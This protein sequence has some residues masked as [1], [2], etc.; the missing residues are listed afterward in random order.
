MTLT[1]LH[2]I[3]A[4]LTL[5]IV[6]LLVL[7]LYPT[8]TVAAARFALKTEFESGATLAER[9]LNLGDWPSGNDNTLLSHFDEYPIKTESPIDH[10]HLGS[11]ALR[12][13]ATVE[14]KK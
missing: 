11:D 4:A 2:K 10:S 14:A 13:A 6:L 5:V 8:W 7:I 3:Q 9:Y 12:V 1:G